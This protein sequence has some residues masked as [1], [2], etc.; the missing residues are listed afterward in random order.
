M[1]QKLYV[2]KTNHYSP[3]AASLCQETLTRELIAE[4][5]YRMWLQ[6][7]EDMDPIEAMEKI[8]KEIIPNWTYSEAYSEEVE[9][10]LISQRESLIPGE[11]LDDELEEITDPQEKESIIDFLW[12]MTYREFKEQQHAEWD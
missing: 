11:D 7:E 9:G 8:R 10:Y 1:E 6:Q 2:P 3:I 12:T 4:N 5:L